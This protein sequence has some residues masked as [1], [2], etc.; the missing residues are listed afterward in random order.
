MIQSVSLW[1]NLHGNAVSVMIPTK[2]E[3]NAPECGN[4]NQ[5]VNNATNHCGLSAKQTG[6]NVVSEDADAAPVYPAND[7]KSKRYFI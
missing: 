5:G 3:G 4:A 6:N 7:D 2:I 1:F